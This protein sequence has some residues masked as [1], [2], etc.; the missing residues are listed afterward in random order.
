VTPRI[1]AFCGKCL[2]KNFHPT[3]G[4]FAVLRWICHDMADP[5]SIEE[6]DSPSTSSFHHH[7]FFLNDAEQIPAR[8]LGRLFHPEHACRMDDVFVDPPSSVIALDAMEQAGWWD[9]VQHAT[10]FGASASVATDCI[11][12]CGLT[13]AGLHNTFV[14]L[15]R[16]LELF[17]LGEPGLEPRPAFLTKFLM[18]F[19]H[20]LGM[21]SD[22][23]SSWKQRFRVVDCGGGMERLALT[24]ETNEKISY[25]RDV[26]TVTLD[27]IMEEI[28]LNNPRIRSLMIKYVVLQLLSDAGFCLQ[29]WEAKGGGEPRLGE[30]T[31][32]PLEKWLWRSL[33]DLYIAS[34]V[35]TVLLVEGK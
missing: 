24:E 20:T 10:E 27:R 7:R 29:R 21:E 9:I 32:D 23:G 17:D 30:R 18:S 35:H 8:F 12:T 28:F 26:F 3:N 33:W 1:D 5:G 16:G 25:L 2:R 31:N 6:H 4:R 11:W 13:D 22:G 14:S 19:F 15:E 34:Y